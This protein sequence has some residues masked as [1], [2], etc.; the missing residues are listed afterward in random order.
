MQET[1]STTV[2]HKWFWGFAALHL[3]VWT[4]VPILTQSN[5]PLDTIEMIFWGHEWEW[6]YYKHPP[7]PPWAAETAATLFGM[8]VWPVY[9]LSQ[10]CTVT[11]LWA[12]WRMGREVLNPWEA[13]AGAAVLELCLYY[14]VTT[15]EFKHGVMANPFWGLFALFLYWGIVRGRSRDWITAGCV[16]GLGFLCRYDIVLLAISLLVFSFAN[17]KV[18][19]QIPT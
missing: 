13:L 10:I 9:L 1:D 2:T 16:L 5:A 7:L 17:S 15:P 3:S 19:R 6:G 11:C 12:A 4:A 18:S 14:S 8:S